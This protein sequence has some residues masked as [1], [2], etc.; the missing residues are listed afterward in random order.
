MGV[1]YGISPK[2]SSFTKNDIKQQIYNN[3]YNIFSP[4]IKNNI[5]FSEVEKVKDINMMSINIDDNN[6]NHKLNSLI[7]NPTKITVDHKKSF[8]AYKENKTYNNTITT[9]NEGGRKNDKKLTENLITENKKLNE[10][11]KQK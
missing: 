5:N 6:N 4:Q 9:D 1:F 2:N 11:V 10:K 3:F 7:N 8:S